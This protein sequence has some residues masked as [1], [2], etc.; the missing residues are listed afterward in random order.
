MTEREK[1][2]ERARKVYALVQEGVDGEKDA[3]RIA[4]DRICQEHGFGEDDFN[5]EIIGEFKMQYKNQMEMRL[6]AQI[7]AV[8]QGSHGSY[9]YK[10]YFKTLY[11]KASRKNYIRAMIMYDMLL[12][13]F[14]KE[15]KKGNNKYKENLK[16]WSDS[17]VISEYGARFCIA[18]RKQIKAEQAR[19]R[20]KFASAFILVHDLYPKKENGEDAEGEDWEDENEQ[21][22]KL[23]GRAGGQKKKESAQK[24]DME[25]VLISMGISKMEV[26][27]R[28]TNGELPA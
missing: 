16:Y 24:I 19:F 27:D 7:A 10:P 5:D 22:Q 25:K 15:F 21:G 17:E 8:C 2:F 13:H 3:A 9:E 20:K 23:I 12:P 26:R 28:V 14:R 11:L 18:K 1:A 4:F 6:L